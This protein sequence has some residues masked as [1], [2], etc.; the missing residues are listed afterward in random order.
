MWPRKKLSGLK[1]KIVLEEMKHK[2]SCVSTGEN[3]RGRD[4]GGRRWMGKK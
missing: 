2:L 1:L 3:L 4:G